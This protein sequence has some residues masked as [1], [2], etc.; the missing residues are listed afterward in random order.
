MEE[1]RKKPQIGSII[2][3]TL[4]L[5]LETVLLLALTVY[6]AIF[7][8]TKGPSNTVRDYFVHSVKETSA[9]GFL[10]N[11][12]LSEEQVDEIMASSGEQTITA[13]DTTLLNI[14]DTIETDETGADAYGLID[15]DGDGIVIE[16]VHGATYSGYMMV[17]YDPKR[18]IVGTYPE[19][20]G[21]KGYTV[22]EYVKRFGA[23]AGT[24][25]GGFEDINGMGDGSV[26]D[27]L[28]FYKGKPT[29]WGGTRDAFVGIDADGILHVDCQRSDEISAANIQ[30]G[31]CYQYILVSNGQIVAPEREAT[32][33]NPRTAIGQ[34]AD[35]AILLLVIDG[36][37]VVSLGATLMDEAEIMVRYGAVNA[38]NMDGGSSSLMYF[39]GDYVNNKAAVI[40]VRNIPTAWLVMP[41]DV[42]NEGYNYD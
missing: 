12:F 27:T 26:P 17:V 34:R 6:G 39:D 8:L 7:V 36:R 32:G 24:N 41:A 37:H 14:T 15:D 30:Y 9:I 22:E 31:C 2:G 33:L 25:A 18:V 20:Y 42:K 1:K 38:G 19:N 28:V 10:A 4:I 13:I 23:V 35:G 5:L 29:N 40:G 16:E 11:L 3:K 21:T